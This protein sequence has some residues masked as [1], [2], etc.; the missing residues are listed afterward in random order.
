[1]HAPK[2]APVSDKQIIFAKYAVGVFLVFVF[3]Q[4][5]FNSKTQA[6]WKGNFLA[7]IH[8]DAKR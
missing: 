7:S 8:F 4:I 2:I 5:V 6:F 1:M 3:F